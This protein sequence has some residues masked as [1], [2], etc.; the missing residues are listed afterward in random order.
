MLREEP[1]HEGTWTEDDLHVEVRA[2]EFFTPGIHP[3]DPHFES[4]L[5]ISSIVLEGPDGEPWEITALEFE[6][7]L[8]YSPVE[9][10]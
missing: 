5:E 6:R 2:N 4:K 1:R 7:L 9:L 10:F 3:D 8:G